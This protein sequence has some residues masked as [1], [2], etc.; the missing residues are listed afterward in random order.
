MKTKV[1]VL[2]CLFFTPGILPAITVKDSLL[3]LLTK[4]PAQDTAHCNILVHLIDDEED[5]L[6]WKT[7]NSELETISRKGISTDTSKEVRQYFKTQYA[8]S[9]YNHAYYYATF[10]EVKKS[11]EY[12]R[13][14]L[15]FHRELKKNDE[16][17]ADLNILAN[18]HYNLGNTDSALSYFSE[19][20]TL[21]KAQHY[22]EGI[23]AGLNNV[24]NIYLEKGDL[25]KSIECHFEILRLL[26]KTKND[27]DIADALNKIGALY[28]SQ[29]DYEK[30]L[31]YY[32]R[33]LVLQLKAKNPEGVS[34]IYYNLGKVYLEQKA[35]T[36]ALKYFD[37]SVKLDEGSGKEVT[38]TTIG[39][40]YYRMGDLEKALTYY[41]QARI[42]AEA[43]GSQKTLAKL[44]RSMAAAYLDKKNYGQAEYYAKKSLDIAQK[45]GMLETAAESSGILYKVYKAKDRNPEALAMLELSGRL[46]DSL[47]R[48]E[49][50]N[51]ALKAEFRY[52][53]EKKEAAI[54]ELTQAKTISE[55]QSQRKSI[56]IYFIGAVILVAGI[57]VYL[58]FARYRSKKQNELLKVQL[59]E[60]E[61]LLTAE[62]KAAESELKALKSQMNP[63]FIFNALNSIQEQF[64]Y[65]DKLKANEQLENFTYLTRQI[66]NVSGKKSITLA[67]ERDILTKYL[68]LERMRFQSSFSYVIRMNDLIDEDYMQ[69]PPMLIQPFVENSIKH[70]LLHKEGEKK[71]HINFELSENESYILCTVEDN[72]IGRQKSAEIKARNENKHISFST[73]SIEQ[74]LEL[75]NKDLHLKNLIEFE[76]LADAA[77]NPAGTRVKIKIPL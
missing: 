40:T 68:E 69:I 43:G 27:K 71:L 33:A 4:H 66:L 61:K 73:E 32:N 42:I 41:E 9:L 11:L 57:V 48:E 20:I 13:K 8:Y 76:D 16:I 14:A 31:E 39:I 25:K 53:T 15:L 77:G 2:I 21:S 30:A 35:Y 63:H 38:L 75:L 64:M 47:N 72:G 45:V 50:K 52:E 5:P 62:K 67:T 12:A 58:L 59:E 19:S 56:L 70:G 55:L 34:T 22:T 23:V 37:R 74:R 60:A 3:A 28:A 54:K 49:N 1:F 26:E 46:N 10:G 7:Y 36:E 18:D 65:G 51:V 6:V 29:Q 17:S 24:A 44:Y